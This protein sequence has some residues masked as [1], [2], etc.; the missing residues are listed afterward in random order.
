MKIKFALTLIAFMSI[1]FSGISQNI[2]I[3]FDQSGRQDIEIT[4]VTSTSQKVEFTLT[5]HGMYANDTTI[6][7]TTFQQ[8]YIPGAN[9]TALT[10]HPA[11]PVFERKIAIP[12]CSGFNISVTV[13]DSLLFSGFN[14]FPQPLTT[15]D[16]TGGQYIRV[17]Q[18]VYDSLAYV[19]NFYS[20]DFLL[21]IP[22]TGALR[23][24]R[25]AVI[26]LTPM[27]YN[28]IADTVVVINSMVVS[29]EFNNPGGEVNTD[30][31]LFGNIANKTLLNYTLNSRPASSVY[32]P[33]Y[34][35]SVTWVD[36]I[37]GPPNA[38][39]LEGDYLII[40]DPQYFTPSLPGSPMY[41][42]AY[43]RASQSKLDVTI[44]RSDQ[45]LTYGSAT[46][47][48]QKIR[49]FIKDMYNG[50]NAANT[51][52]GKLAYVLLVGDV[53]DANNNT[54]IPAAKDQNPGYFQQSDL[55]PNDYYYS[56]LTIVSGTSNYDWYGDVFIGRLS[57]DNTDEL[58]NFYQKI[59]W[60]ETEQLFTDWNANYVNC[61]TPEN[62]LDPWFTCWGWNNPL[63]PCYREFLTDLYLFN[64]AQTLGPH[65]PVPIIPPPPPPA[66]AYDCQDSTF[67]NLSAGVVLMIFM[68]HSGI[69]SFLSCDLFDYYNGLQYD[70][71][72]FPFCLAHTCDIGRYDN[73]IASGEDCFAEKITTYN[74]SR[75]FVGIIASSLKLP[76]LQGNEW[77][78]GVIAKLPESIYKNFSTIAGEFLL[79]AKAHSDFSFEVH[80]QILFDLNY[81]GDPALNL[82]PNRFIV[83]KVTTIPN[84][85][86]ISSPVWVQELGVL[87]IPDNFTVYFQNNGKIIVENGGTLKIGN[88]VKLWGSNQDNII[89]V[90]GNGNLNN[91]AGENTLTNVTFTALQIVNNNQWG[92]LY[93]DN[94]DDAVFNTCN[95]HHASYT[96]NCNSI[97]ISGG[98]D[99]NCVIHTTG[100][101]TSADITNVDF[102]N[103]Q[104]LCDY[105]EEEVFPEISITENDFVND[106]QRDYIIRLS[107]IPIFSIVQ[108]DL[109]YKGLIGID[110]QNIQRT[111]SS[112]Q[113][114]EN[115][116]ILNTGS[117]PDSSIGINLYNYHADIL[118]GNK[119]ENNDYGIACVRSS[120][121]SIT[122]NP[123]ASLNNA[124]SI[125]DN[126]K[127]QIKAFNS[128]FPLNLHFN[129]LVNT[130]SDYVRIY[131]YNDGSL[132]SVPPE[133]G[134]RNVVC[135]YW[136][137]GFDC[138]IDLYPP[139]GYYCDG[140][141]PPFPCQFSDEGEL[142]YEDA[143]TAA[144]SG[145]I[146]LARVL[147]DSLI[148]AY[149]Y[150]N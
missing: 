110:L 50:N 14:I 93:I 107:Q 28:P 21:K 102:I 147:L 116:T 111:A 121:V 69:N 85:T 149:P 84:Y 75:G 80:K 30:V 148:L 46:P 72:R 104:V 56:C 49:N 66:L 67:I 101:I 137:T 150:S 139:E 61:N 105:P 57:V 40:V 92:G 136:G 78:T 91:L 113:L 86:V 127:Y 141:W 90:L 123:Y 109:N 103:S 115:N 38:N 6:G 5:V 89:E 58:N 53:I 96:F 44:V 79:E 76:W 63:E 131:H 3:P 98:V 33:S 94:Q 29:V 83:S 1:I 138:D 128:S 71:L 68:G 27:R 22:E 41:K 135:N 34:Q 52:D 77:Q 35:G 43:F 37:P 12:V 133:D 140:I 118:S 26:T 59:K 142:L 2:W 51:F 32:N 20:P 7:P 17:D 73:T 143:K 11:L 9:T 134:Y 55:I 81:F 23:D 130:L 8:I 65:I 25:I 97:S 15:Y 88:N 47:V 18:F 146:I 95:F 129:R 132:P 114:I 122:G 117:H 64:Q 36:Q 119:V 124:Q 45:V 112:D 108:N 144:D 16:T 10:G 99:S 100:K 13:L 74:P 62:P 19:Q 31:G 82:F 145:N 106:S 48:E 70:M 42:F 125:S 4:N 60:H 120:N 39:T 87:I 126:Y 54:I 24:Q